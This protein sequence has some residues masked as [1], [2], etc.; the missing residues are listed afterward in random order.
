MKQNIKLIILTLFLS[1]SAFSQKTENHIERFQ[2]S[3]GI[4]GYVKFKTQPTA[5]GSAYLLVKNK[6]VVIERVVVNTRNGY[7]YAAGNIEDFPLALPHHSNGFFSVNGTAT[8]SIDGYSVRG[9]FK[10]SGSN[11]EV[12]FSQ[13][14]KDLHNKTQKKTDINY[15]EQTGEVSY[16]SIS[17]VTGSAL[18]EIRSAMARHENKIKRIKEEKEKAALA[19]KKEKENAR[20]AKIKEEKRKIELEKKEALK[21][22]K[23]E[24]ER[25]NKINKLE[26]ENIKNTEE[27]KLAQQEKK[28]IE[29]ENKKKENKERLDKEYKKRQE[30][31]NRKTENSNSHIVRNNTIYDKDK[32]QII[33]LMRESGI[34]DERR[35]FLKKEYKKSVA[36]N[37]RVNQNEY[38]KQAVIKKYNGRTTPES[39]R[40]EANSMQVEYVHEQ[41]YKDW[42]LRSADELER[43]TVKPHTQILPGVDGNTYSYLSKNTVAPQSTRSQSME[44]FN[45]QQFQNDVQNI[46]RLFEVD[47][48]K[49]RAR[50]EARFR[51]WKIRM[52]RNEKHVK[53]KKATLKEEIMSDFSEEGLAVKKNKKGWYGFVNKEG[54]WIIKPKYIDAQPFKNGK[55]KVTNKIGKTYYINLKG[56]K[57]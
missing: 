1:I 32:R 5:V 26:R 19:K 54:K 34:S 23:E 41:N 37:I 35:E 46:A 8:M 29:N 25:Q 20:L 40:A 2:T 38:R 52:A 47:P 43:N 16:L 13:S 3:D 48:A 44:Y 55:S 12:H 7:S 24:K 4:S 50:Q 18:R 9:D 51:S 27:K 15:W 45:S 56:K 33:D 49:Q 22:E 14:A 10:G 31:A 21:K 6:E 57:L 28:K 53:D 11:L 17:N 30:N 42:L 39:I 36:D